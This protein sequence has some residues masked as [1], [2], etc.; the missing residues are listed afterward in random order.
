MRTDFTNLR[1]T[2]FAALD[3]VEEV[4]HGLVRTA[5]DQRKEL[6]DVYRRMHDTNADL[7]EI[8]SIISDVGSTLLDVSEL[9]DDVSDRMI[10]AVE[11]GADRV[12]DIDYEDVADFCDVCGRAIA[13]DE[14]Y[15][16]TASNW[17]TCADC[18]SVPDEDTD[19]DVVDATDD[20]VVEGQMSIDDIAE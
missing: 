5:N 1:T 11:C 4:V 14:P 12:P 2:L 9:A 18:L 10:E 13:Y 17:V 20:D 15:D 7:C 3:A 6:L 19:D 8:G 16:E